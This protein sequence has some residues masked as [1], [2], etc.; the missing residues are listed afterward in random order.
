MVR[1][2]GPEG[3]SFAQSLQMLDRVEGVLIGLI[4]SGEAQRVL[5]RVPGSFG[6]ASAVNSGWGTV[7]LKLWNERARSTKEV[8]PPR[9]TPSSRRC[10]ATAF[11]A[12]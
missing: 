3:A 7:L 5:T 10:R 4:D 11:S 2:N 12:R 8:M 6:R 9:S 1:I